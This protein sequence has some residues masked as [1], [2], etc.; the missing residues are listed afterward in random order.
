[1]QGHFVVNFRPNQ[2][3]ELQA[4]Y[5]PILIE[6]PGGDVDIHV[7]ALNGIINFT[8]DMQFA[9]QTQYDNISENFAFL[10]RFRWEFRPGSEIFIAAGQTA[11]IAERQ[12]LAQRTQFSFRVGHT[13]R[14]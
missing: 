2:F 6:L 14:F 10:G 7:V 9:M 3:Y 12:F 11:T 1:M 8:P 5:D 13:L 4:V